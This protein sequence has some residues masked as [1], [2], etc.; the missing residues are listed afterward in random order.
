MT[1][2]TVKGTKKSAFTGSTTIPNGSYLDF[3]VDGKNLRIKDTDFYAA[4]AVTGSIVQEGDPSGTPMLDK[5]GSVN[6]IRN[7]TAGFGISST[8]NAYNGVTL[9]ASSSF[10]ETGATLV[11]DITASSPVWR[12]IVADDGV[13][14]TAAAGTITLSSDITADIATQAQSF[15]KSGVKASS[16]EL[17][18]GDVRVQNY[19][20]SNSTGVVSSV[21]AAGASLNINTLLLE[22]GETAIGVTPAYK[23]IADAAQTTFTD[24]TN[25]KF[26]FPSNLYT[27]NN[28]Y[29]GYVV[30]GVLTVDHGAVS[31]NQSINIHL[32]LKRE[33]DDS[34]VSQALKV[35]HNQASTTG[36]IMAFEFTTFVNSETDPY[37]VDGIYLDLTNDALSSGSFTLTKADVRI[38]KI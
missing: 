28:V 15:D 3:V 35:I 31:T 10:D 27:Y 38:F 11:D 29:T 12:S 37:V 16:P 23:T 26:L 36:E 22:S 5:Q 20:V 14:V 19:S 1:N 18:A 4:L 9:S 6:A 7:I 33:V 32:S 25:D 2:N 8:I 21:L 30:R 24:E 13:V 34:I 17:I